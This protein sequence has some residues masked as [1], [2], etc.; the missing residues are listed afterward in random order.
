M[1]IIRRP[2]PFGELISLRPRRIDRIFDEPLFRPAAAGARRGR[3]TCRWTSLTRRTPSSSRPRCRASSPRTS[4]SRSIGDIADHRRHGAGRARPRRRGRLHPR[5][6]PRPR[7]SRTV[8]LPS[9]LR[10]GR[11]ERHVRARHAAAGHPQASRPAERRQIPLTAV[12]ASTRPRPRPRRRAPPSRPRPSRGHGRRPSART[13]D[14]PD[15]TPAG[16]RRRPTGRDPSRPVYV[17]SV[18]A[19]LVQRPSRGRCASTRVRGWSA[20]PAPAPTSGS[21]PRTTSGGSSGSAT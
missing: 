15:G 4:R 13:P 12:T 19:E 14:R 8:T 10:H 18:A 6:A 9:G 16:G 21:T 2:S 5:G 7:V 1:T 11:G 17:I 20:Q 3:A